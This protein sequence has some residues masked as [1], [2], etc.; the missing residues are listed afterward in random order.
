MAPVNKQH[1]LI[2]IGAAMLLTSFASAQ[3]TIVSAPVGPRPPGLHEGDYI[4]FL[5]VYSATEQHPNGDNTYANVHTDYRIYAADGRLFKQVRNSL[6]PTDETPERMTLPKG[7]YVVVAQSET[8]GTV[9]IPVVIQTGK[10][11]DLRL[12]RVKDWKPTAISARDS[13]YVRLPN[14]QIIGYRAASR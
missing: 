11:T 7:S 1:S 9:H 2:A 8:M 12:E 10:A 14:G 3:P 5:T 4:G 13:D 6:S